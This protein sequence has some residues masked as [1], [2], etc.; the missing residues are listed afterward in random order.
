MNY[1]IKINGLPKCESPSFEKALIEGKF[2]NFYPRCGH[3]TLD[4]AELHAD[5]IRR[6]IPNASVEVITGSHDY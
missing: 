5:C 2:G 4:D 6:E 3:E 1:Y